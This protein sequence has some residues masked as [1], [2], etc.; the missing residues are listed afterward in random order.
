MTFDEEPLAVEKSSSD[1]VDVCGK[2]ADDGTGDAVA[3]PGW[4]DLDTGSL[5]MS[6]PPWNVEGVA[7]VHGATYRSSWLLAGSRAVCASEYGRRLLGGVRPAWAQKRIGR[8]AEKQEP[9]VKA[10]RIYQRSLVSKVTK[11]FVEQVHTYLFTW[12]V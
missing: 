2:E 3:V 4:T 11:P 5:I 7:L 12:V 8:K 1:D 10:P 9:R 6:T